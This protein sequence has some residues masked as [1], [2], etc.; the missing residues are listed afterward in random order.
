[1]KKIVYPPKPWADK[2]RHYLIPD[3]EFIYSA[4]LQKWIPLTVQDTFERSDY[5]SMHDIDSVGNKLEILETIV[6]EKGTLWKL[7]SATAATDNNDLYYNINNSKLYSYHASADTWV[8]I[9]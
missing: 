2:D 5:Q 3:I 6:I 7:E 9:S 1:M 4:S 8:Q